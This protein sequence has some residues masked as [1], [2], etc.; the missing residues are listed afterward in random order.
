MGRVDGLLVLLH[1]SFLG[2]LAQCLALNFTFQIP[3]MSKA[4]W[5][6]QKIH[7]RL[8]T[9]N[10]NHTEEWDIHYIPVFLQKVSFWVLDFFGL[11][12]LL[13]YSATDSAEGSLHFTS[14][15]LHLCLFASVPAVSEIDFQHV[16]R[17]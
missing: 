3:I 1:L 12:V 6:T 10:G 4:Y 15:I 11:F 8:Q 5:N 16:Y 14:T 9:P 17:L 2:S 13:S 7:Y